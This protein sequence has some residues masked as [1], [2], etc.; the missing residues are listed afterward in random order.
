MLLSGRILITLIFILPLFAW[1][2]QDE[3]FIEW[4]PAQRLTWADYL[5]SPS[6][7]SDAAAITS[8]ALGIE[9]HIRNNALTYKISCRFSKTRSWGRFKT[10]YI[11][12]HEQGHFDITEIFARKLAKEI[13]EYKFN[14]K[15]YQDDL[16]K[17]YQKVMA[18]KEEY[19]NKYDLET[20]YS[21]N[22]EK[23]AQ[24]LQKIAAEL[25]EMDGFAAYYTSTSAR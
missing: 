1:T 23:Q 17:I 5:A 19:Q 20:D 6:E 16:G 15:K 22:K 25:E 24:W 12:Q 4:S 3:E 14:P 10:A 9:Y 13:K 11:L 7:T 2:Q 21:R 8:T 18:E